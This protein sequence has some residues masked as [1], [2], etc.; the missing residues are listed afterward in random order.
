MVS[1]NTIA[2]NVFRGLNM[3]IIITILGCILG[4]AA[5]LILSMV[6]PLK[7]LGDYSTGI[8]VAFCLIMTSAVGIAP[9]WKNVP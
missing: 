8:M 5:Y 3:N 9:F 1:I 7:A 4:I 2:A 6:M